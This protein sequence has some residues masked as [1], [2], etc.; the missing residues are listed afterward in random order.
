MNIGDVFLRLVAG[1]TQGFEKSVVKAGDTAGEKAGKSLGDRL[2]AAL[3]PKNL[4]VAGIA[5]GVALAGFVTA[6]LAGAVRSLMDIERLN[7]QTDAAIRATG[8]AA[9]V[10]RGHIEEVAEGLE[11]LTTTERETVQ[12]GANL[13]LTFKRIRNE[14]GAGND[15][16]D[17]AT[18]TALDLSV[19]LGTDM[20]SAS[21]MLGKALDDPIRGVTALRRAGV[22][23]TKQQQEQIKTF[24]ESGDVLS[25]QKMILAELESQVGGSAEAFA[26]T[27]AGKI[28][29]LQNDIGNMFESIVLGA[30]K[31]G[32][33]LNDD[34]FEGFALNFG[35][36]GDRVHA[37]ADRFGQDFD[38]LKAR[39]EKRMDE[40][41]ESF[42]EAMM[43]I[44]GDLRRTT[45]LM[46]ETMDEGMRATHQVVVDRGAEIRAR[47]KETTDYIPQ[48]I[49]DRWADTKEAAYQALVE[50]Q[51]GVIEGQNLPQ[52]AFDAAM[53]LLEEEMTEEEEL[54]ELEGKAVT[55]RHALGVASA[56]GKDAA[57]AAIRGALSI[58]EARMQELTGKA[59]GYGFNVGA[60]IARGIEASANQ[61]GVVRTASGK[62]AQAIEGQIGI[63]SEPKAPDSPLRGITKWGGNIVHTIADDILDNLGVGAG[64]AGALAGAL[65]PSFAAASLGAAPGA[66]GVTN[67]WILNVDGVPRTVS[68]KR[69]ALDELERVGE[70][71]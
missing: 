4:A 30:I 25:A 51:K 28:A 58:I 69:E 64:A 71:W 40:T 24:V 39:V 13:L 32:E 65:V 54:A 36:Q 26:N 49:R 2:K 41:G 61:G 7:A 11:S 45:G 59:Y 57:A 35:E 17:R 12:E 15:I 3:S 16:F 18:S 68:S 8:G 10:T 21:M 27:T 55:L 47:W 50:Y 70:T 6:G 31:V 63:R 62:L 34:P 44:E 20:R 29:R 38:E 37:A 60:E 66:G 56:E 19:A 23:L 5:G 33:F 53:Q 67:Q 1:D 48:A 52:V 9:N 14:A 42:D 46:P 22:A 43:A